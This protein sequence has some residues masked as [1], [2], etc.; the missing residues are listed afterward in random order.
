M[1]GNLTENVLEE[2]YKYFFHFSMDFF[3]YSAWLPYV[4][5]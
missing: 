1:S 3:S 5:Y 4:C 2:I